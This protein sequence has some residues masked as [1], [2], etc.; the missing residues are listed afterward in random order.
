MIGASE[1]TGY[2]VRYILNEA[3][4]KADNRWMEEKGVRT[5]GSLSYTVTGLLDDTKYDVQVRGVNAKGGGALVGTGDRRD[6]SEPA[7]QPR[8]SLVGPDLQVGDGTENL[9]V[10]GAFEDPTTT[11]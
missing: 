6:A 5:S 7:P 9:D 3:P 1:V 2:D 10:S 11:H 8:G 4:D